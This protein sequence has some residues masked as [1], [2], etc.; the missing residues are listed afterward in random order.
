MFISII[1]IKFR[2]ASA[3]PQRETHISKHLGGS[4]R[5]PD[6]LQGLSCGDLG[7][8]RWLALSLV[9]RRVACQHYC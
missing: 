8:R 1:V 3:M 2:D 6:E 5:S 9:R 4:A 7:E